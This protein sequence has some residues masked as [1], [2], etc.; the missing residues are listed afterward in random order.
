MNKIGFVFSGISIFTGV[1]TILITRII[2]L[3]MPKIGRA[4]YQSAAAGSYSPNDYF[5]NFRGVVAFSIFLI[6][7]GLVFAIKF[8]VNEKKKPV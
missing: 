3:V 2:N 7:I 4:A 6:L 5:I 8:Y 1:V